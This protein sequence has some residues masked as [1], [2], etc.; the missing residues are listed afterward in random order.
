MSKRF[1]VNRKLAAFIA[2]T[3]VMLLILI[4]LGPLDV[5]RHGY[6]CDEIDYAQIAEEDII[7]SVPLGSEDYEMVFSPKKDY[8]AGLEIN[9]DYHKRP[10]RGELTLEIEDDRGNVLDSIAVELREIEKQSWYKVYTAAKLEKGED[11]TLRFSARNCKNT[12]YLQIVTNEYLP[13]E[14]VS[15]N[16]LVCYAYAESTFTFQE[17]ILI[18]LFIIVIWGFTCTF[19]IERK[20]RKCIRAVL[21]SI[22]M[23]SV[24]A[25]NYMYNS[26]D[27][28]NTTFSSFQA[29]SES[30]VTGM[31][32]ADRQEQYFS[33]KDEYGYGMGQYFDL[34]GALYFRESTYITDDNWVEGYSRK[35]AAIVARK[36][37][38]SESVAEAGN[39]ISF[40]N[41]DS[42]KILK[43]K[44][45]VERNIIVMYLDSEQ[46]LTPAKYG[47]LDNAKFYNAENQLLAPCAIEA[48]KSQ[49]G[50][51]GKL[52][53][54]LA[55]YMDEEQAV[56]N[57]NLFCS[58]AAAIVFV[59]IVWLLSVKYNKVL[60]G[61]F[62]VTFWLS[63]WIVNFARSMYWLE[64]LWFLPMLA[65]LFCAWKINSRKCRIL[66]Y[67]VVFAAIMGKCLC[68]YEYISV[69]MMGTIVFLLVDFVLAVV[70]KDRKK[71]ILLFRTI[72]I[73]GMVAMLGF[74]AAICIHASLAGEGSIFEGIKII[75][76]NY[77]LKR[78][79]G[80]DMNEY[81]EGYWDSFNASIWEVY[82]KYFHF[83]TEIITGINGNLFP[84]LCVAPLA[85]FGCEC[86]AK[87]LNVEL[88]AMYGLF[89]FTS[90]SWFCLAKSHSYIHTHMNFVLWYFGFVQICIYIILNKFI[91]AYKNLSIKRKGE[92]R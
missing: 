9:I 73:M 53:K 26:M 24:L 80:A 22:L 84:L 91:E 45:D 31:I 40:D 17:K 8:F 78:T 49:Y 18:G 77:V 15:G 2:N 3:V 30:L 5:F 65:G 67:L 34:K 89:F 56:A 28:Q 76:E 69:I 75:F 70:N 25:W 27:N 35:R 62:F 39:T 85:I 21:G 88:A 32:N 86:K 20:Y 42:F 46:I 12:P 90:I 59:M 54:N 29:D 37:I 66:S 13:D 81:A 38:Y 71:G 43:V 36:N 4:V 72:I 68:G 6:F 63:P 87:K 74:I 10:K 55:R 41:G 47:S 83:S 11:Y 58:L 14:T 61:V 51:Q 92:S 7:D 1:T 64:G 82:C 44:D 60:A 23:V 52:F 57:F 79:F 19:F 33:S 48:Y 50:L 16:A